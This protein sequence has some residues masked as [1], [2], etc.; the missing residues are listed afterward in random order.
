M[1]EADKDKLVKELGGGKGHLLSGYRVPVTVNRASQ[2]GKTP[3][4]QGNFLRWVNLTSS[5]Q[6]IEPVQV[7]VQGILK[8]DVTVGL[9]SD[10]GRVDFG[11][12]DRA[13]GS[14]RTMTLQSNRTGLDLELDRTRIPPYVEVRFPDQPE[15]ASSGHRTWILHLAIQPNKARGTF[16]RR[17]DP[18]YRDSAIYVKT[19]ELSPRT[20]RIPITGTANDG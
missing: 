4:E 2:D 16:P 15:I 19:K 20:I 8:G 11:D 5:D 18:I 1:T 7:S 10:E 17:D 13:K 12:F 9:Q 3:F 6:G 14:R